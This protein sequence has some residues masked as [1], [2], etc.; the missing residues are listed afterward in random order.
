[1]RPMVGAAT[2]RL[3]PRPATAKVRSPTASAP[4]RPGQGS[5]PQARRRGPLASQHP[6][7]PPSSPCFSAVV[8]AQ[9]GTQ[10]SV[11]VSSEPISLARVYWVPACAGTTARGSGPPRQA[12]LQETRTQCPVAL[13]LLLA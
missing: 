10:Y 12:R 4:C 5:R 11:Q 9:A 3:L 6:P 1:P 7:S 8:P 2:A 13:P